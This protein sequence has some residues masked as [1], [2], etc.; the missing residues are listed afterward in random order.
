MSIDLPPLSGAILIT[1]PRKERSNM[2]LALSNPNDRRRI[3]LI[4]RAVVKGQISSAEDGVRLFLQSG[5][6]QA[7]R[8]A[9]GLPRAGK[10]G[11]TRGIAAGAGMSKAQKK[12]RATEYSRV[13]TQVRKAFED[14]GG[15]AYQKKSPGRKGRKVSYRGRASKSHAKRYKGQSVHN[16]TTRYSE[17]YPDRKLPFGGMDYKVTA[18]DNIQAWNRSRQLGRKTGRYGKIPPGH[19]M[20]GSNRG[21][22]IPWK[23]FPEASFDFAPGVAAPRGRS[24][25]SPKAGSYQSL[26]KQ[27]G[28]KKAAQMWRAKSNPGHMGALALSNP[29]FAGVGSFV[30]GYALPVG[31]S[32]AAAGSVHAL[33]ASQG[34]TA[35]IS[36]YSS[37]VPVVGEFVGEYLPFTLQGVLAGSVLALIAPL[38]GG[39]AGR[40]LALTA[41]GAIAF[42]GGI[43]AFNAI[44]H[45]M[46]GAPSSDDVLLADSDLGALALGDLALTNASALGDIAYEG[47][48]LNGFHFQ[49]GDLSSKDYGQA[50]LADAFYSGADFS[51]PEG[52]ALLNG[53]DTFLRSFGAPPRRVSNQAGAASHLAGR[54]GHRWGWLVKLVGWQKAQAIAALPPRKRVQVLAQ[55]RKA[56]VASFNQ[57]MLESKVLS[58]EASSP[59]A[60]LR[61]VSGLS[62]D[63]AHGASGA[64]NYLGDPALF[65]G[66]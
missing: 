28:V 57:L 19:T 37:K 55:L 61:P 23:N 18:P 6:G 45:H 26:V 60:E 54:E 32:G 13:K 22:R 59:N 2:A 4:A 31:I 9:V 27:H 16:K 62:A 63:G 42:G 3:N 7:F 56:A 10:E 1:N 47:G 64:S 8:Q 20:S 15:P 40:Y 48:A 53:R 36:E 66:A 25:S 17:R 35:K 30:T 38:V 29:S 39:T 52:Q 41:G 11:L 65:Q 43:D 44:S 58:E 50:S 51:G 5:G 24:S 12:A 33:A 21:K 14:L 46:S 49:G 34:I